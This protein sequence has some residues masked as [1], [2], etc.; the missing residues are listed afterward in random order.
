M[1]T[2]VKIKVILIFLIILG[3][4]IAGIIEHDSF[5]IIL[6]IFLAIILDAR[7]TL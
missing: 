3:L 6:D 1:E 2:I 7:V 5:Y 4:L